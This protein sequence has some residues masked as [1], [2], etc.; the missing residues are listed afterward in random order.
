[1]KRIIEKLEQKIGIPD[2][3]DKILTHL[4]GSELNT[5]LLNLFRKRIQQIKP[6]ELLRQY[7]QNRFSTPATIDPIKYKEAEIVWLEKAG[8]YGFK[9]LLLSP[10]TPLGSCSVVGYVD[11]NNVVSAL[12]GSEVV[13]DAT[14][15]L[16]LKVADDIKHGETHT[17]RRYCATHRLVRGQ[18]YQNPAFSAH[19]GMFCMV[20]GGSH[21]NNSLLENELIREHVSFYLDL[22][23]S[24]FDKRHLLVEIYLSGN[25]N[26][27]GHVG[28]SIKQ[29]CQNL[30]F[31]SNTKN[32][33]TKYYQVLRFK[34]F[35]KHQ[36]HW[37]DIVD[38]GF[39]DWTQ[40]LLENK[41]QKLFISGAGLE[42]I[43]KIHQ[44][45]L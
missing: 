32:L 23:S 15:V 42:I 6:S 45:L 29:I 12:R 44:G 8:N 11:Q 25:M 2:L 18:K 22:L 21:Q 43:H 35:L 28:G 30:K 26:E 19:F 7:A 14:N 5:L 27:S 13:S 37:I 31:N 1:M 3:V 24:T 16:A 10:L 36:N 41:R 34:I 9:A 39:V 33:D 38:G 40:K 20:S 17:I 4:S